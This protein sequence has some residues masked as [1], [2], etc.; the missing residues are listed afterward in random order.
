MPFIKDG[1]R[2][3]HGDRVAKPLASIKMSR[4]AFDELHSCEYGSYEDNI[5][6]EDGRLD[7]YADGSLHIVEILERSPFKTVCHLYSQHEVDE[8]F[9]Q[10]CTGTFGLYH[11]GVCIRVFDEL[12]PLVSEQARKMVNRGTIG[13]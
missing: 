7:E 8:F 13:Y 9:G 4:A 2:G 12:E 3:P 1:G 11:L 5:C 6:G 10:C